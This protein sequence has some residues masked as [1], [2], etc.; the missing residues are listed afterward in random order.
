MMNDFADERL[1]AALSDVPVP[2][3]LQQRLLA[4]LAAAQVDER[5]TGNE[6]EERAVLH[7]SFLV[8]HLSRR[9]LVAGGG[10]LTTAALLLVAVWSAIP[11][12]ES[13]SQPVVL[14]E[15]IRSFDAGTNASGTLLTEKAAPAD[16]PLSAAVLPVRGTRWRP[17]EERFLGQKGVAYELPGSSG[18]GA[19][20]YVLEAA[21]ATGFD[22]APA[23]N[24][25]T[26]AGCCATAWR[27]GRLLY[28][29]VVQGDPAKYRAYLNLPHDPMA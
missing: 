27:E 21:A 3:G 4:C 17:L 9:W 14:D 12:T 6:N 22:G 28:V 25:F 2:A 19:V 11:R 13:L 23:L 8:P 24:P 1:A 5:A 15:A 29:L 16:Y 10:L 7:S 20:L 18:T 26:T